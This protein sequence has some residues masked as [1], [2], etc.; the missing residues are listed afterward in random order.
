[1]VSPPVIKER[2]VLYDK[3]IF[4]FPYK[5]LQNYSVHTLC[6]LSQNCRERSGKKVSIVTLLAVLAHFFPA[7]FDD[8]KRHRRPPASHF[9]TLQNRAVK[10]QSLQ[11]IVPL[12]RLQTASFSRDLAHC[13]L[14]GSGSQQ[15]PHLIDLLTEWRLG[16]VPVGLLEHPACDPIIDS[17]RQISVLQLNRR[18]RVPFAS[19]AGKQQ[20]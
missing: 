1:M 9:F 11:D 15:R 14:A 6:L 17:D 19:R 10:D 18:Q 20:C 12:S 7:S 3:R 2:R 13:P 4:L 8:Q 5:T 16:N